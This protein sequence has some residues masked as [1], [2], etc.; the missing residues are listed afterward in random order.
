MAD[1]AKKKEHEATN[2]I[3]FHWGWNNHQYVRF[4]K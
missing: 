2:E 3:F 1:F 4:K